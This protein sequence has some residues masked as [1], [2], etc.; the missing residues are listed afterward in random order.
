MNTLNPKLEVGD[1][2][3]L[4]SM[5]DPFK[6]PSGTV[7]TVLD[8]QKIPFSDRSNYNY[9]ILWDNGSTLSLEP[10][11]DLWVLKSDYDSKKN[12]KID[13]SYRIYEQLYN[14]PNN[15]IG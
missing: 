15:K 1:R 13:E 3:V 2:I 9:R 10:D 8:I 5:D 11:L 7:G 14:Q 4:I 12:K 6:I